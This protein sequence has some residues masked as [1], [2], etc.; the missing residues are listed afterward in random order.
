MEH[1]FPY[2]VYHEGAIPEKIKDFLHSGADGI[3][4]LTGYCP[5]DPSF[6]DY[7]RGVHL[8]Y[9][10]DWYSSWSGDPDM[11]GVPDEDII[12]VY[13]G[14]NRADILN[15]LVS[16]IGHASS[17]EPE[18]AVLHGGSVTLDEVFEERRRR[19][20][21]DVIDAL[22]EILN[23]VVSRFK[24]G[25]PPFTILFENLW[26]SGIR[27]LDDSEMKRLE[28]KLE[29]DDWGFCLDTGHMMNAAGTRDSEGDAI[30]SLMDI[31][32][33][34]S[35]D[36]K[37][38][39]VTMHLH[40]STS[41]ELPAVPDISMMTQNEKLT[42]AYERVSRMDQHRPFTMRECT[43][44][45]NEIRPSFVTHEISYSGLSGMKGQ[46]SLFT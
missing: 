10:T 8:P 32:R 17:L 37:E 46:R 31:F 39:I 13:Y 34:Y 38:R 15:N 22:A 27:L 2:S 7:V 25:R 9:A 28:R 42:A 16:A 41:C 23:S 35:D 21:T 43:A 24:G 1:L 33:D 19:Y 5:V 4:L 3:E 45:V 18:Y 12:F 29:F 20:D 44:L 30:L 6:K 40:L 36:L 26:W 14:R 11:T